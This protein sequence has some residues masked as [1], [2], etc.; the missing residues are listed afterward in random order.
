MATEN[1]SKFLK[2]IG[3]GCLITGVFYLFTWVVLGLS[4]FVHMETVFR[5]GTPGIVVVMIGAILMLLSNQSRTHV[6]GDVSSQ[7]MTT[8]AH[9][10]D[11]NEST[12]IHLQSELYPTSA[13]SVPPMATHVFETVHSVP[14][15]PKR[16]EGK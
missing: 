4:G 12:A 5:I 3:T 9:L 14:S 6:K 2:N 8:A 16:L 10:G 7:P 11:D 1:C 15:T 13:G